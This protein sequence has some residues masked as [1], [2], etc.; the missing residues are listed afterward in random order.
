MTKHD[1]ASESQLLKVIGHPVRLEI[2]EVL[3]EGQKCVV[4]V[5]QLIGGVTQSS[6][7]Q[8]LALLRHGG[9]VGFRREGNRRCYFLNDPEMIIRIFAALRGEYVKDWI[10]EQPVL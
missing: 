2:L 4:D 6:I 1:Y 5:E 8:H 9:I 10:L 7:S 3:S